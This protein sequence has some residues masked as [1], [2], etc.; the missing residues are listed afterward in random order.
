MMSRKTNK[1]L[2]G[3][4]FVPLCVID[5]RDQKG[6]GNRLISIRMKGKNVMQTLF[7]VRLKCKM[8]LLYDYNK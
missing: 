8:K 4:F 5:S 3:L 2:K 7:G 1:I 6:L